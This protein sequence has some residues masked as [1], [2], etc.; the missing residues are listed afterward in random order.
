MKKNFL[1]LLSIMALT[2]TACRKETITTDTDTVVDPPTE[3]TTAI[4]KGM[5]K[6]EN[7]LIADA[8][9][10]V[11]EDEVKVGTISSGNDGTFSTEG[12]TLNIGKSITFYAKKSSYENTAKRI[13]AQKPLLES[14]NINMA[15]EGA[16][17]FPT[18]PLENPGSQDLIVVSGYT[19]TATGVPVKGYVALVAGPIP[20]PNGSFTFEYGT[21]GIADET[22]Y[23]EALLPKNMEIHIW[24]LQG[25]SNNFYS[26][27]EVPTLS[28]N[29]GGSS[30]VGGQFRS[31][32][33]FTTDTQL[34]DMNNGYI[35]AA[36]GL[37]SFVAVNCNGQPVTFGTVTVNYSRPSGFSSYFTLPLESD[38]SF[39]FEY[40]LCEGQMST[41]TVKI[42]DATTNLS[43]ALQSFS[44]VA[45]DLSLGNVTACN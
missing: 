25:N 3:I 16:S 22:G 6:G 12:I 19:T 36:A 30:S 35:P 1:L 23:Y 20:G 21:I 45:S 32:G 33:P 31:I 42:T 8:L 5:V 28:D 17:F 41:I 24:A 27:C 29:I 7:G 26:Y 43:S 40:D 11:Y 15:E 2:I 44:N 4:L 13:K 18:N 37:L 10:D 14:V 39:T 9:I 38:G 34:P